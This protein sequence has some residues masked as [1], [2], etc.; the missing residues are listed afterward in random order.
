MAT[1]YTKPGKDDCLGYQQMTSLAAAAN[2]PSIP[3]G[4]SRAILVAEGQ[5]VRFRDDGVDPTAGVGMPL[6]VGT[7][8]E[9]T[10]DLSKIRVIQQSA[11]ATL[12]VAYYA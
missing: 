7:I 1:V 9:Y 11:S 6:A 4:A 2:L 5:A 8:F 10:G 3:S 12:N